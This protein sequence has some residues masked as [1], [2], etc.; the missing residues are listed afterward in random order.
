MSGMA[1]VWFRH[2]N[3]GHQQHEYTQRCAYAL[4]VD[5]QP[6]SRLRLLTDDVASAV[7]SAKRRQSRLTLH[8]TKPFRH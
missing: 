7:T 1:Q 2:V 3:A 8:G 4:K 6:T 5:R